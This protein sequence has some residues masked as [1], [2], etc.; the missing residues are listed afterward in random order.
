M[1]TASRAVNGLECISVTRPGGWGNPFDVRVY[2]RE[3]SMKLFL[4]TMEGVWDPSLVEP[5]GHEGMDSAYKA[6]DAF[7]KRLGS[8]PMEIVKGELG[9]RNLACYCK[10]SEAC[11]A[12][13]LLEL[14]NPA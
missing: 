14:S 3:L 2:G 10:M 6:H 5:L 7:L 12:E 13:I 4:N 9:G 8:Q 1:Q 11:H